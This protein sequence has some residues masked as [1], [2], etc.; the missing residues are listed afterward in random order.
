M[1]GSMRVRAVRVAASLLLLAALGTACG[2]ASDPSP[3]TG[4]DE[5]TVPT[6]SPDPADFVAVVDNPWFPLKPGTT[7]RYDVA[8]LRGNHTLV[9]TATPGPVIAGVHTTARVAREAGTDTV[10]WYA[11]D[12]RGNVWWFGREGEWRAGS[13]AAEAGLAMPADPRVGDGYR[14]GYAPGVAEDVATVVS[15]ADDQVVVEQRSAVDTGTRT[16]LTY[17]RGTGLV[18]ASTVAGNYRVLRLR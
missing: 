6:P 7:W 11:Q 9:V 1:L 3:P 2:S 17:R 15:V 13:G 12:D 14:L 8:D 16:D 18:L 4:V 5:L 10:D